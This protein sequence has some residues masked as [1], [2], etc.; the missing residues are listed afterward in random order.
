M[1][2]N[3]IIVFANYLKSIIRKDKETKK[4]IPYALRYTRWWESDRVNPQSIK[5]GTDSSIA[6]GAKLDAD[7]GQITI[8]D[9]CW[10]HPGVLLLSY[11]GSITMG[12]DC[13][14]NPYSILYGHGGLKIGSGVRIAAHCV[15]IPSNHV[16][17]KL[18]VP[19]FKQGLTK[20]GIVIED[21]VWIGA[22][23]TIL[24]GVHIGQGSI[25]AAGS[26]VNKD[27]SPFSIVG[28]V[29]AKIIK[30]RKSIP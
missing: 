7:N 12:D 25:I 27:V 13:T 30:N 10:I 15:V 21:D 5:I 9:R 6:S 2:N 17:D 29:P 24:D 28:G 26:V 22:H 20:E 19:I 11:G 16:Y 14:V 18:D 1:D 4:E 3:P 23:V 8:G